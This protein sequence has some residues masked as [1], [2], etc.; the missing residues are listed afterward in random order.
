M[1]SGLEKTKMTLI[2]TESN[3]ESYDLIVISPE[4]FLKELQSFKTHKEKHGITTKIISLNN[5]YNGTYFSVQGR[6]DP[7]KIKYFIKNA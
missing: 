6:D 1:V 5:I 2:E 7:E 4:L 3:N